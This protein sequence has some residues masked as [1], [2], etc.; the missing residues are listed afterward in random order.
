MAEIEGP[1]IDELDQYR[2]DDEYMTELSSADDVRDPAADR[3]HEAM[4]VDVGTEIAR[5]L[6]SLYETEADIPEMSLSVPEDSLSVSMREKIRSKRKAHPKLIDKPYLDGMGG[7][8]NA[9]AVVLS[10]EAERQLENQLANQLQPKFNP[11]PQL[12]NG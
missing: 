9:Q 3:Q 1:K 7:K 6:A 8:L 4:D 12:G 5:Q 11:K 2:Q 10:E